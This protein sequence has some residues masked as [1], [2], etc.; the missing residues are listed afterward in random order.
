MCHGV[1]HTKHDNTPDHV[2][3]LGVGWVCM[4][5]MPN[6]VK[7]QGCGS[8]YTHGVGISGLIFLSVY[9]FICMR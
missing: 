3:V 5:L 2:G 7:K 8:R 4:F 9:G 1:E 6:W